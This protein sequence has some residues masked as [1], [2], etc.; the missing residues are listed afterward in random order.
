MNSLGIIFVAAFFVFLTFTVQAADIP[1]E[2]G[3]QKT[4]VNKIGE[5][6]AL[7]TTTP[8]FSGLIIDARGLGLE[9]TF[10]PVIYDEAG[11]P[12]YG[13][14]E[15]DSG[16]AMTQGMADYASTFELAQEAQNGQSRAGTQPMIIKAI[17]LKG[18]QRNV[19]INTADAEK[20]LAADQ[21][22]KFL[23]E[24]AVVFLN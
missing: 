14:K 24:G 20:I 6:A 15:L 16:L 22:A 17:G 9:A 1:E 4:E 19:M 18:N 3:R 7:E 23:R 5:A 8:F 2:A 10:S 13:I 21:T 11:N 12:V